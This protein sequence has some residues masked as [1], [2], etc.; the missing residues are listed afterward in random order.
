MVNVN[1]LRTSGTDKELLEQS[2]DAVHI[3][4]TSLG[5]CKTESEHKYGDILTNDECDSRFA[6]IVKEDLN[7]RIITSALRLSIFKLLKHLVEN[8][9]HINTFVINEYQFNSS[10]EEITFCC[11]LEEFLQTYFNEVVSEPVTI[12]ITNCKED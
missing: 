1:I 10:R 11:I 5:N 3:F 7:T 8:E 6:L 2:T 9:K 12:V 4:I